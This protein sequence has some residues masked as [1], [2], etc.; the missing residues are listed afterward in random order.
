MGNGCQ[1]LFTFNKK[2]PPLQARGGLFYRLFFLKTASPLRLKIKITA[3]VTISVQKMD[4]L[5][6]V[7]AQK[8][9]NDKYGKILIFGKMIIGI[10]SEIELTK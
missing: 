5:L 4:S 9:C 3:K 1:F 2:K 10:E 6:A 8:N 7:I